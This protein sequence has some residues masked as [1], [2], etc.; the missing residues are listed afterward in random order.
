MEC[1]IA[2][3]QPT[4]S[5]FGSINPGKL[6]C[7]LSLFYLQLKVDEPDGVVINRA[8]GHAVGSN[9]MLAANCHDSV[10]NQMNHCGPANGSLIT[11][12]MKNNHLIVETEERSVSSKPG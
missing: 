7:L 11:M 9:E 5:R 2:H 12:T 8:N 4:K 1:T 6:I 10:A 3:A